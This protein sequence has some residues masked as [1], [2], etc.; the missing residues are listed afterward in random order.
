M[1]S[2]FQN[3]VSEGGDGHWMT[4]P[5]QVTIHLAF[6]FDVGEEIDLDRARLLL[7]GAPGQLPRRRRTPESIGYRP[8]PI[9]V[10]VEPTGLRLPGD[11][12]PIQPAH[13]E[14]TLFDFGAISL[15][16][17][18]RVSTTAAALLASPAASPNQ[19]LSPRQP[20]G[21]WLR[22]ST[23]SSLRFMHSP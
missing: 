2:T 5:L 4:E 12:S 6:A 10:E 19:R 7:Q 17:Q 14:L 8:A 1:N 22:G 16:V 13:S 3:R 11:L 18:F 21:F 20:G 15:S 23:E 9:T